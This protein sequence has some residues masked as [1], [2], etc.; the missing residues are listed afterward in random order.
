MKWMNWM[1]GIG[2]VINLMILGLKIEWMTNWSGLGYSVVLLIIFVFIANILVTAHIVHDYTNKLNNSLGF[3]DF[4][5][6]TQINDAK[7]EV[8]KRIKARE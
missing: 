1:I 2:F 4:F 5:R 7:E 8:I 6:S 3:I